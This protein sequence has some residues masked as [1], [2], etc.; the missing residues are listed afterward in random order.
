MSRLRR[1]HVLAARVTGSYA[2]DW[3]GMTSRKFRIVN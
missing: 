1:A 2:P 3:L